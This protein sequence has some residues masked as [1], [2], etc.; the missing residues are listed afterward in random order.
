MPFKRSEE[1]DNDEADTAAA[2]S[3]G[4]SREPKRAKLTQSGGIPEQDDD[5]RVIGERKWDNDGKSY[6]DITYDKNNSRPGSRAPAAPPV[7]KQPATN[8]PP[9]TQAPKP[10]RKPTMDY[11]APLEPGAGEETEEMEDRKCCPK[12]PCIC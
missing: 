10:I 8:S 7:N 2:S 6:K 3:S 11:N 1:V 12:A 4:A 9:V 5:I